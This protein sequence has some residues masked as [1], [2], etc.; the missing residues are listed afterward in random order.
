M[1]NYGDN[2]AELDRAPEGDGKLFSTTR[3]RARDTLFRIAITAS[4][5]FATGRPL[6][7]III[8]EN[9]FN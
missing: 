5:S 4:G 2:D 1:A 7:V 8:N 3:A 9:S 6:R